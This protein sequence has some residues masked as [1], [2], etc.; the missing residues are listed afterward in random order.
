MWRKAIEA[1]AVIL[2]LASVNLLELA[3]CGLITSTSGGKNV[4]EEV[5]VDN[6][7]HGSRVGMREVMKTS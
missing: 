4:S 5:H 3:V 1:E 7:N 6:W 2:H